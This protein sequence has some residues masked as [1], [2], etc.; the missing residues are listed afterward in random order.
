MSLSQT[1]SPSAGCKGRARQRTFALGSESQGAT[2]P[3]N[4]YCRS[5]IYKKKYF[6]QKM[7]SIK[8]KEWGNTWTERSHHT[9]ICKEKN[10]Q[11]IVRISWGFAY[12]TSNDLM[13]GG[14]TT[15][16]SIKMLGIFLHIRKVT[17]NKSMP[18]QLLSHR[19]N[20]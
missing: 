13:R 18:N 6:F 3:G 19:H 20:K 2:A 7:R 17:F 1:P 14:G 4:I 15:S 12:E 10:P 11:E 16:L 5:R 8:Y 9:K